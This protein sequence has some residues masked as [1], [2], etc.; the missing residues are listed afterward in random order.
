ME[1]KVIDIRVQDEFRICPT[2]GYRDGFHT[3]IKVASKKKKFL[4]ICPSCHDV[5]NP[6]FDIDE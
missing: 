5:F 2:C 3:M 4:Y 6:V 1:K